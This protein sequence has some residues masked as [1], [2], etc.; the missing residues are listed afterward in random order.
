MAK[1]RGATFMDTL[2]YMD[3]PLVVTLKSGATQLIATAIPSDS[4]KAQ[5]L[6]VT[7]TQR[8]W[9][10]Y[11]DGSVDLRYLYTYPTVRHLYNFNLYDVD[12]DGKVLM[13]RFDA[14]EIPEGMLPLPRFFSRSHTE[15]FSKTKT[16]TDVENLSIDGEWDMPEFGTFYNKYSDIY[17]FVSAINAFSSGATP[18]PQ[19]QMI[20]DA[21]RNKP[22]KGGFS[23]VHLYDDLAANRPREDRL[24]LDQI[25]YASPG[26]VKIYGK[27]TTFNITEQL[28]EDFLVNRTN[29][30]KAYNNLHDY[31]SKNKYLRMSGGS[32]PKDD[33]TARYITDNATELASLMNM[34][35]RQSILGLVD[36]NALVF[37]KVILSFFRRLDDAAKFFAQGRIDFT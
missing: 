31:L 1:R 4:D 34:P 36:R 6:A 37:A 24:R 30:R 9:E 22:F 32:Y 25:K 27:N 23:Y 5:F 13:E 26:Y 15:E 14:E 33:P 28:I 18:S 12:R 8:D 17:Y 10:D 19:R 21:F 16:A 7:V 35:E 20:V 2:V 3:E 29:I 11:L